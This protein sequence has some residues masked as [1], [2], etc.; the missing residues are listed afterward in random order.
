MLR[1][2]LRESLWIDELHTS[3]CANA[4]S[5]RDVARRAAAGNQTPAY[6]FFVACLQQTLGREVDWILRL[7]S[8]VAWLVAIVTVVAAVIRSA[9]PS[10]AE[11]HHFGPLFIVGIV[12]WIVFDRL[13]WFY[14]TEARPYAALQLVTFAGWCCIATMSCSKLAWPKLAWIALA[15][16][17]V[18]LHLTAALPVAGQWLVG[19][20]VL[21]RQ[22]RSTSLTSA[23]DPDKEHEQAL[24]PE[25]RSQSWSIKLLD[26]WFVVW[27]LSGIAVAIAC[28][29]I[30]SIAFPVWQRRTQWAAFAS[31]VSLTSASKM[32][33]I[34]P[35][36]ACVMIA[37][38]V[39]RFV[40]AKR[41]A[42]TNTGATAQMRFVWWAALLAPWLIAW[43]VTALGIAP[44][45]HRR[46]VIACALPLVMVG[47]LELSR[48]RAA[49]LRGVT[50]VLVTAMILYSQ[51]SIA[52]WQQG[53]LVGQLR[54]ED[55]RGATAWLNERIKPTDEL[56]CSS[57]LVEANGVTLPIE[58]DLAE[59]LAFPLG[60][61]YEVRSRSGAKFT[62]TPLIADAQ[63]WDVQ[64]RARLRTEPVVEAKRFWLVYRGAPGRLR[65]KLATLKPD[66][67]P[68]EPKSFGKVHIVEI[69]AHGH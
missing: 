6:F 2:A 51:G 64:I 34:V 17:S 46:F 11:P 4:D 38:V 48:V 49:W 31:D 33:P 43:A 63:L 61:V 10:R 56:L 55:W 20:A 37:V 52:V 62:T 35:I 14:A 26:Q 40:S 28:L 36:V 57:G 68:L 21:W 67:I 13:H 18:H 66:L 5:W 45:F 8:V 22:A 42:A 24:A 7:P 15:I 9:R 50:L 30:L 23:L 3:W 47:A 27:S 58:A 59:Y 53:F 12:C 19:G 1:I 60:G 39:D 29:P 41:S 69:H 16:A 25:N 54:G 32:F 65:Q 44:V